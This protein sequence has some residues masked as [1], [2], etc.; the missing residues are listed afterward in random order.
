MSNFPKIQTAIPQH[1]YQ[2]GDFGITILGEVESGD[3]RDYEFV[4]AFVREGESQPRL[5][6]VSERLPA[7]QRE[8]G[9]H[10]IRLINLAM[11]E[12]MEVGSRWGRLSEFTD[13]ALK[14]GSQMLGLDQETPYQLM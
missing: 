14:L 9:S 3:A 13:Q 4:A 7:G 6:V 1:R 10:A 11:D 2:Y 5:F 8:Q 12:V